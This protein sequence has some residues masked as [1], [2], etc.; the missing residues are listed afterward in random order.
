MCTSWFW[1]PENTPKL[2]GYGVIVEMDKSYFP[3]K[4][5]FHKGRCLGE[6]VWT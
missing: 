3:G 6:E 2:G 4:P 1:K 5:K